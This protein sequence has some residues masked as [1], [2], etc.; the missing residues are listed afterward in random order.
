MSRYIGYFICKDIISSVQH[1]HKCSTLLKVDYLQIAQQA[2]LIYITHNVYFHKHTIRLHCL[3]R[4]TSYCP[5]YLSYL[6]FPIKIWIRQNSKW[7]QSSD[8]QISLWY[9]IPEWPHLCY[10][11]KNSPI[12]FPRQTLKNNNSQRFHTNSQT[13]KTASINRESK[14]HRCSH[15]NSRSQKFIPNCQLMK[16]ALTNS[17][18]PIS[19]NLKQQWRNMKRY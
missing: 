15:C 5:Y 18:S 13:M 14:K 8:L 9:E 12:K 17:A 19:T 10:A 3:Q 2:L 11:F 6:I 1:S 4:N 16:N 7:H